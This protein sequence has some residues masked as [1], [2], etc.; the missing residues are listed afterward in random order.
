METGHTAA[1]A[2]Q[3]SFFEAG[4]WGGVYESVPQFECDEESVV[5]NNRPRA[6]PVEPPFGLALRAK[7]LE[8]RHSP[9]LD[10]PFVDEANSPNG[11][12]RSAYAHTERCAERQP[13]RYREL[14][15]AMTGKKVQ[16]DHF[17]TAP[18]VVWF[19]FGRL[20]RF[21]LLPVR[22]SARTVVIRNVLK[23]PVNQIGTRVAADAKIFRPVPITD[24]ARVSSVVRENPRP[25]SPDSFSPI[26][27]PPPRG[28]NG[29]HTHQSMGPAIVKK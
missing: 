15:S 20:I 13:L 19:V 27:P 10:S 21:N 28:V 12:R 26:I 7:A 11:S 17:S 25:P 8:K 4:E 22:G 23:E 29:R 18:V 3:I 6:V 1:L 14:T 9:R 2:N 24:N 5:D 16:E